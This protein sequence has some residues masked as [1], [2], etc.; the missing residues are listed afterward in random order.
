MN[1]RRTSR[2]RPIFALSGALV[3]AGGLIGILGSGLAQK[4]GIAALTAGCLGVVIGIITNSLNT[5]D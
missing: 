4:V 2:S 1:K 5:G 3:I